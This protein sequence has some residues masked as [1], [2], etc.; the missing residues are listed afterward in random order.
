MSTPTNLLTGKTLTTQ[1]Q[2]LLPISFTNIKC[3]MPRAPPMWKL[4]DH[5]SCGCYGGACDC[6]GRKIDSASTQFSSFAQTEQTFMFFSVSLAR[7]C[8]HFCFPVFWSRNSGVPCVIAA[9]RL[10]CTPYTLSSPNGLLEGTPYA[11]SSPDGLPESAQGS[12]LKS[13]SVGS[14]LQAH[15]RTR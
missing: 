12:R 5:P 14:G 8:Q 7:S 13:N 10:L 6:Q 2:R 15:V 3:H 11:L 1:P 4:R 9:H